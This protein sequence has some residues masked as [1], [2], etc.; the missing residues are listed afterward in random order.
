VSEL[1][2]RWVFFITGSVGFVWAFIWLKLYQPPNR[3]RF[4]TEE[5]HEYISRSM[6]APTQAA[7]PIP[8][9]RLFTYRQVWGLMVVKFLTDSIW[10]FY[11]FWLPKYL[12]DVRGLNIKEIGYFAWIPFA[13]AGLGSLSGGW[14]STF[15]IRRGVTLDASRK[16]AIGIS[17]SLMP[18]SLLITQSPLS[19]AIIFFSAALFAHQFWSANVQTLPA[20]IFPARVVG[21]VEGLLGCAGSF[22]GMLS[23]EK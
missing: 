14:L 21:S 7:Q 23:S 4:I 6:D 18:V 2:W 9:L 12:G 11:I 13:F 8:W 15:L 17:A 16:I 1:G 19:F 20:D 5:E 22:G 10:Y 3:N